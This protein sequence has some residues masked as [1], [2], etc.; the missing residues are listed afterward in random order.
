[1]LSHAENAAAFKLQDSASCSH[2]YS[3]LHCPAASRDANNYSEIEATTNSQKYDT[4][5]FHIN[6]K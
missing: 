2:K 3:S 4:T 1:M 6:A 5:K